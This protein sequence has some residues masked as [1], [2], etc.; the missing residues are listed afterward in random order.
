MFAGCQARNA[1]TRPTQPPGASFAGAVKKRLPSQ[2]RGGQSGA[3]ERTHLRG[4]AAGRATGKEARTGSVSRLAS[5]RAGGPRG[6][7]WL[8]RWARRARE[9]HHWRVEQP[10]WPRIDEPGNRHV[11]ARFCV[12]ALPLRKAARRWP[13]SKRGGGK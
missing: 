5:C 7:V 6:W 9:K 11:M 10:G 3:G 4:A 12:P 1:M 8:G 13:A 2:R